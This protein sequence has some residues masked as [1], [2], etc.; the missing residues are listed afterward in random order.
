MRFIQ[1]L[2]NRN[3]EL[4]MIRRHYL[5]RRNYMNRNFN[6]T[7]LSDQSLCRDENHH[8]IWSH[9]LL[10]M[11][12]NQTNNEK[13]IHTYHHLCQRKP[14][15]YNVRHSSSYTNVDVEQ[16]DLNEVS[17]ESITAQ[18]SHLKQ[19]MKSFFMDN[20][21]SVL[22]GKYLIERWYSLHIEYYPDAVEHAQKIFE[23]LILTNQHQN[24]NQNQKS[25]FELSSLLNRILTMLAD[26]KNIQ[27]TIKYFHQ[28]SM[29][30]NTS[31]YHIILKLCA[32]HRLSQ[33]AKDLILTMTEHASQIQSKHPQQLSSAF[34][35]ENIDINVVPD[36]ISFN[37]LLKAQRVP[38][39]AHDILERMI[40]LWKIDGHTNIKPDLIS[41]H[42]VMNSY[43]NMY[44]EQNTDIKR[45]DIVKAIL[46]LLEKEMDGTDV[47]PNTISYNILLHAHSMDNDNHMA[48][49]IL[50]D[51][52]DNP[53]IKPDVISFVTCIKAH[54]VNEQI[55]EAERMLQNS[56]LHQ[57]GALLSTYAYNTVIRALCDKRDLEKAEQIF[58]EMK[59][60]PDIDTCNILIDA[61]CIQNKP[62]NAH[63]ILDQLEKSSMEKK[64]DHKEILR[65][66]SFSYNSIISAY[67][68]KGE[69]AR[70]ISIIRR[71][72]KQYHDGNPD[73]YPDT[74]S[75]NVV[76]SSYLKGKQSLDS[77]I[78]A[79][80]LLTYL[81][82]QSNN[83]KDAVKPDIISYTTV[84]KCWIQSKHKDALNTVNLLL[85]KI[86]KLDDEGKIKLDAQVYN[87]FLRA[88]ADQRLLQFKSRSDEEVIQLV[89]N[90][91]R[92]MQ[93][94]ATTNSNP[95]LNPTIVTYN[96]ILSIFVNM[97][98]VQLAY[99]MLQKNDM[100][101]TV[102]YNTVLQGFANTGKTKE[103][104]DLLEEMNHLS[105]TLSSKTRKDSKPL[106]SPDIQSYNTVIAAFTKNK[107]PISA[108]KLL[109]WMKE[110]SKKKEVNQNPSYTNTTLSS[111]KPN[112]V[113]YANVMNAY[114][115][116]N[117]NLNSFSRVKELYDEM[118]NEF[119]IQPD[120]TCFNTVIH[121][122]ARSQEEN[123][124]EKV[125]EFIRN[126][127]SNGNSNRKKSMNPDLT[128]LNTLLNACAF[129]T[130]E[131]E[132]KKALHIVLI[133]LSRIRS[134]SNSNGKSDA[135]ENNIHL[136]PDDDIIDIH[137]NVSDKEFAFVS[138]LYPDDITFGTLA[139][140]CHKL[141]KGS[142]KNDKMKI[143][144]SI[145]TKACEHGQVGEFLWKELNIILHDDK[146]S[147]FSFIDNKMKDQK[148][149][150][151]HSRR[152]FPLP[153][154][155]YPRSWSRNTR[156]V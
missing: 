106:I 124:A 127:N 134:K 7:R 142:S 110:F 33:E 86:E 105:S 30:A 28:N 53:D 43:A 17:G 128:T 54:K 41:F 143:L 35:T 64:T 114:A 6:D 104:K 132:K 81:E 82:N 101:N 10:L 65:P 121:A 16:N 119:G 67:S 68:H 14:L 49:Q 38:H 117:D 93:S 75:Y 31:S 91:L 29:Y 74:I 72:E 3:K 153:H 99:D 147:S 90:I 19:S 94:K 55:H 151:T 155:N 138:D 11:P 57:N 145:F 9:S 85:S 5:Q 23:H 4:L 62:E 45:A 88:F 122:L 18:A 154:R 13:T 80:R 136:E 26:Y 156:L 73:V 78:K 133:I 59:T 63:R 131:D 144:K 108:D 89:L 146:L 76:L 140:A 150:K 130:K 113:T 137:T 40:S 71:M 95:A 36:T 70:A 129:T 61:F 60:K 103:A 12:S 48:E 21:P 2:N 39:E 58:N 111:L 42:T 46:D 109:Q 116:S 20:N 87:V 148:E 98:R 100:K 115:K 135:R 79:Q 97:G 50:R 83:D 96:T 107:D 66:N 32:S 139:K 149:G 56:D 126:L 120:L 118:E 123:K 92:R 112:R 52:I 1:V 102:S 69:A 8:R 141:M 25:L 27:S 47:Q 15:I 37:L 22:K 125:V 51:M 44:L 34:K 77:A 152:R 84:M 24:Q